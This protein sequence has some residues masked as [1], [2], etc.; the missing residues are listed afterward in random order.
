MDVS[1]DDD[2]VNEDL[3]DTTLYDPEA[4]STYDELEPWILPQDIY[5]V[6]KAHRDGIAA[7]YPNPIVRWNSLARY[8]VDEDEANTLAGKFPGTEDRRQALAAR[9][10]YIRLN[11]ANNITE[12]DL[13]YNHG[14]SY[15]ESIL[16]T[17]EKAPAIQAL[18][19][20][21]PSDDE[22]VA[23]AIKSPH[24]DDDNDGMGMLISLQTVYHH[25]YL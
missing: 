24:Q 12:P 15:S 10:R 1:G 20:L 2:K 17:I 5:L 11:S 22:D 13:G 14:E 8:P 23:A 3:H 9:D 25:H 7:N 19:S 16:T 4:V 21:Y 6:W 18:S